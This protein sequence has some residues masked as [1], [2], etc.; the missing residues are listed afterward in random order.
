M[1]DLEFYPQKLKFREDITLNEDA[2]DFVVSWRAARYLRTAFPEAFEKA[3]RKPLGKFKKAIKN[4]ERHI[5]SILIQLDTFGEW[6]NGEQYEIELRLMIK[7]EMMGNP[8]LVDD[9]KKN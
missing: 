3:L 1:C 5:D 6:Q 8:E 7:S 9:L 4:K 2:V